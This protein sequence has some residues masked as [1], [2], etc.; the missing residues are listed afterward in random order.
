MSTKDRLS[1]RQRLTRG[2]QYTAVGPVDITR[3]TNTFTFCSAKCG[4][5]GEVD[6]TV[7]G[8]RAVAGYD[9]SSGLGTVDANR[10]VSALG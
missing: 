2:L 3:G 6:T 1:P 5:A 4:R 10:F 7:P 8:F 9:M